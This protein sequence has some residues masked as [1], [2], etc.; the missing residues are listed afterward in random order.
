MDR[1]A[2]L[3]RLEIDGRIGVRDTGCQGMLL[4]TKSSRSRLSL[5]RLVRTTRWLFTLRLQRMI[6]SQE[7]A[8]QS[9]NVIRVESSKR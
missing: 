3:D 9:K 8:L 2:V 1:L 7:A 4:S 5:V 6:A